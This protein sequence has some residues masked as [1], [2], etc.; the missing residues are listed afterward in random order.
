[1]ANINNL[2]TS[3]QLSTHAFPNNYKG[4]GIGIYVRESNCFDSSFPIL[5]SARHTLLNSCNG[6]T[7][8]HHN[9]VISVLQYASPSAHIFSSNV[10][11]H[12]SNPFSFSPPLEIATHSY[13][14]DYNQAP[15]LVYTY[16]D[17]DM[18]MDNYIYNNRVIN[19]VAAGNK[20]ACSPIYSVT[21]P[22]KALNAI[23]VG[24][25]EPET[26]NYADYS[27]WINSVIGNDKPEMAIYTRINMDIYTTYIASRPI[28]IA[29]TGTS[30]ATPLAAG[31]LAD[32][33]D[34]HPFCKRQPAMMKATL[35]TSERIP[36]ANADTWDT[37]NYRNAYNPGVAKGIVNYSTASWGTGSMWWDGANSSFFNSSNEIQPIIENNIQAG[38]RYRIAIAWLTS[39]GYVSHNKK[40]S[41]DLDL[42]VYQNG[43]LIAFSLSYDNPFEVVNFVAPTSDPLSVIIHRYRNS[44]SDRVILGY[45]R[46][47]NF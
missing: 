47:S 36:I 2:L 40:V 5:E 13:C 23:T 33:L 12:P 27:S 34:Q 35:I 19:F 10:N 8:I 7:D 32:H 16:T 46:N 29:F 30:A 14:Y 45:H 42:Y 20:G 24:A 15:S 25:V 39:G 43:N 11:P 9:R 17:F 31:F 18:N 44:G 26:N 21:S 3:L 4:N 38:K 41:Q 22:G 37:D 28:N 6:I 1:M